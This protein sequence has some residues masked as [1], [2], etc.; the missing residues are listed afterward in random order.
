VPADVSEAAGGVSLS[1]RACT[2]KK[3][4]IREAAASNNWRM[5]YLT[6]EK[7]ASA[8]FIALEMTI[9]L[10]RAAAIQLLRAERRHTIISYCEVGLFLGAEC[11]FS[12]VDRRCAAALLCG[13]QIAIAKRHS[14]NRVFQNHTPFV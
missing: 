10:A 13:A 6:G 14:L 4:I 3:H 9:Q 5:N 8:R 12:G 11:N 2:D 7:E 1:Q